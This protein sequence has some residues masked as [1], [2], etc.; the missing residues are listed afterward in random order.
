M[1]GIITLIIVTGAMFAM[2]IIISTVGNYYS[3]NRI[4][5][6]TVGQGQHGTARWATKKEIRN[7]YKQVVYQPTEWRT[8]PDSRP[9]EQGIVVGCKSK[10][11]TTTA[12]VDTSDVHALMI[13][14]AG[15][16]KTAYWLYPCIEYACATGMSFLS[17]D[18]KGDVVRNYGTIA[19]KYYGY[20]VSVIDLRNPTR[21]HGNNLLHLVNK[22][23]DL[24]KVNPDCLSYKAKAEKYAKIISKTIVSNGMD[25]ASFGENSYFY[26][27]AEGLLTATILLVAEFCKPE[28]RHIVSAYKIIQELLAPSGQKGKNQFQQLMDLL[29]E[30]HKA[31]W[32]AGA[33]LNTSEQSIA[34]VMS[35]ALS[36]LNA[37]LDSEL[38]QILCFDTE[39]D[40]ERFCKEKSA[41][42]IVMPEENPNT[43][44]MV[45][46]IIQ[47][48]YREILAVAD[49]NGGKLKN[50]CVFFCD[51]FGTLPKIESAEMM[52]SASRSRRLQIVPIIQSFAQLEQNY[53]KEGADVIIDNTQLTIFGGFAPNS[54]SAEVLS[55]SLG[56]RTVMSGS[57]SKSKNDPSQSLQMIERPLMTPDEL[58]SL[59]KGTFVVVKTGFYP[60]KVKLKLFFKWGI[61]F[62]E[63]YQIAENGNREVHYANRSEL[64][65]NIIQT[66]CPHYLEQTVTDSDFDEASGEKKKKNENLKTSPNA[67]QTECE[68]IVDADEPTSA[69]Q[70]EPTKEPENSSLEQNADK[71]RKVVVRTE[72]PPQGDN[73]N[74]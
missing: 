32:F 55:K 7:T 46:L 72:R 2:F 28:E 39:I 71:Q 18:T 70:D 30:N 14:A 53:G 11:K 48:L 26:D 40:A 66:Y 65:N 9:T 10:G 5:D 20:N 44:F 50:R 49:E 73:S 33:A 69:Q 16:G 51:E 52:F 47:Q 8:N 56:S 42:F 60:M 45:S 29:P 19:E 54:T 57:V 59:P 27:S 37:F 62:E 23:F 12:L 41:I 38:E 25:G 36:R 61:E 13:G 58:K 68:D 15:V 3:L 24:Y 22:Y 1:S 43:F 35:T 31:K 17:T 21:S 74:E 6:K 4:K 67:E 34:S 63:Q 64:F